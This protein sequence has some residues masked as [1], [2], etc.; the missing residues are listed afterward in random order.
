MQ[1]ILKEYRKILKQREIPFN[2][3]LVIYG[4]YSHRDTFLKVSSFLAVNRDISAICA[5][6]D[7]MASSSLAAVKATG[8]TIPLSVAIILSIP[9]WPTPP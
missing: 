3:A 7:L 1:L 4:N 6:S 8:M 9:S 2:N 5:M